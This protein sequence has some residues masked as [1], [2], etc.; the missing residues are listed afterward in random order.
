MAR[1]NARAKHAAC[2]RLTD[3]LSLKHSVWEALV[4]DIA[5]RRKS[6]HAHRAAFTLSSKTRVTAV[7]VLFRGAFFRG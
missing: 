1:P 3:I 2:G 5:R 4:M 6:H 7:N